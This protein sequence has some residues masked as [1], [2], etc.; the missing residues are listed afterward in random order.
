MRA[1]YVAPSDKEWALYYLRNQQGE[2]FSGLPY[3]RGGG[4]GSI[5]RGIFRALLPIAKSAGKTVGRQA[6]RT[7]AEI[8]SD[9]LS[10][11]NLKDSVKRRSR[12]AAATLAT[13][14]AKKMQG[15][16]L[17][18]KPVSKTIK[19]QAIK[20]KASRKRKAPRKQSK[21]KRQKLQDILGVYYK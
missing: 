20:K 8:A 18:K 14:A 4:L 17:G 9:V 5:F 10:G 21:G 11:S 16:R 13:K 2:G 12:T 7:G 3:Q 19:G 6:L 1:I 15:G